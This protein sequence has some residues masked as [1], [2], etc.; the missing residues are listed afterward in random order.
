[1]KTWV[2]LLIF[3]VAVSACA[4]VEAQELSLFQAKSATTDTGLDVGSFAI[5]LADRTRVYGVAGDRL[6]VSQDGGVAWSALTTPEYVV[7]IGA[8]SVSDSNPDRVWMSRSNLIWRSDNGGVSWRQLSSPSVWSISKIVTTPEGGVF[9]ATTGNGV[10]FSD[11]GGDFWQTRSRGLPAGAGAAPTIEIEDLLVSPTDSNTL[12]VVAAFLGVFKSEDGGRNWEAG[13]NG[14]PVPF[15]M[16]TLEKGSITVNPLS[17]GILYLSLTVPIH[18][19][20]SERSIFTSSNGAD[21][22]QLVSTEENRD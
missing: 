18:S 22:W 9:I 16:P 12:F 13:N 5:S 21:S 10:F 7:E 14:L 8:L 19:H 20:K 15:L 3:V 4:P 2:S 11:S 17:P 6:V 1:M